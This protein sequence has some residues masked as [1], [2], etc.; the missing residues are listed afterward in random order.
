[1]PTNYSDQELLEALLKGEK[2]K[3][4]EIVINLVENNLELEDI[5]EETIKKAMYKVGELWEY[6][7]I[8]VATEHLASAIVESNLNELYSRS[9]IKESNNK[10]VVLACIEKEFHQIGLKMVADIF[11][12]F[13][14]KTIMLGSNVPANELIDFISEIKPELVALSFSIY[15]NLNNL[16][17]N[18]AEINDNFP[19]LK[20]IVGGQAFSKGGH[21][22][23]NKYRNVLYLSD[24]HELKKYLENY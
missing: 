23:I 10:S 18:L 6:G 8:S 5:Y 14:W 12:I 24:L 4:S 2:K 7:K 16:E 20:I 1:M 9:E 21:E 15:F 13:G 3:S 19:D 11:E 17:K 22:L